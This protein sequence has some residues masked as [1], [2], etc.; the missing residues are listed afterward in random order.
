MDSTASPKVKKTKAKGV[1]VHS[2]TRNTSGVEGCVGTPGWGLKSLINN[3][4]FAWTCT[5][6]TTTWLMCSW[7]TL[8]HEQTIGKHEFTRLTTVQSWGKPSPFPLKYTM[9]LATGLTPKC[10]FVLGLSS[11]SPK[12]SKIGITV[13]LGPITLCANFRLKWGLKQSCSP[14]QELSNS[15]CM[16]G[17]WVI[18]GF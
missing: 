18:F 2:L 8:V 17:N 16:Q 10:H 5:N 11:G 13:T 1:R 7:G 14:C 9:C 4:L 12:F 15:M 6:Q 3:S